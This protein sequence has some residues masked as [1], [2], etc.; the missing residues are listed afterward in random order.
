MWK[1][2]CLL[3][4]LG[5]SAAAQ[6]NPNQFSG[7]RWRLVGPFRSGRVS[8]VAGV[9]GDASTYYLGN[10]EGGVFKT[11][12]GGTVWTPIFAAEPVSSIGALAVAPSNPNVVYV[13]SGDVVN[14]GS[15]VN[16]GDGVYKSTDA[17]KTWQHLGLDDTHHISTVLISPHD[18]N[19]VLVAALGHTFSANPER[20]IY[21][22]SD[23]GTNWTKVLYRG[24]KSG[25]IDLVADPQNFNEMFAA[26]EAHAPGAPASAAAI[27]KSADAGLHWTELAG[28]GMPELRGRIGLAVA[29]HTRGQRVF[30]ITS[31]GLYRSDDAGASWHRAT[32][33]RRIVGAGYFSRVYVSPADPDMVYVMQ[34]C[35]YR[36][37]DGGHTFTAWKGA[38]GGDDYHE[39]WIDP[40]NAQR[41][42]LGVDQGETI[43]LNGGQQWS[44]GWT[45]LANGQFYH[46]S[47]DHRFP[48][49]IYGTQQDS[50]SAAVRSRGDFGEITF[51]DWRPSVGAY[52]FGYIQPDLSDANYVFAT[53]GGAALNRYDWKTRQI[54]DISPPAELGGIRLRYATSPEAECGQQA[55]C[56]GAQAV[57]RTSDRGLHWQAMSP[58][59]TGGG[60]AAITALAPTPAVN[61]TMWVGTSDGRVVFCIFG[62][63]RPS[64]FRSVTPS[65]VPAG[66]SISMIEAGPYR[67]STA[68]VVFDRHTHNDFAPYIFRTRDAGNHWTRITAGIPDGDFVRVVRADAQAHNLLFAGTEHGAFVSFNDGDHWQPLQ[69][70]LP[71]VSVRDLV[72][73]GDDLVAGTYGRAIWILDDLSPLRALAAHPEQTGTR[74][75]APQGA[76]RV[77]PDVNYDT[78][79]PPEM[80]TGTNPPAGAI[81]DYYLAAPAHTVTLS[82]Y[83]FRHHLIRRLTST[84]PA[85]E[86]PPQLAIPNY[87][88]A[89]PQPLP[90]STGMHRVVWDL[91]YA[92]PP[93]FA[94]SQPIAALLHDTP[95]DPRGP[96]VTPGGYVVVLD[97]DGRPYGRSTAVTMDPRVT[98]LTAGLERQRDLG[99][100]LV[101]AMRASYTAAGQV[102]LAIP[103]ALSPKQQELLGALRG[104]GRRRFRR[105]A[106]PPSGPAS[107]RQLNTQLG[108]LITLIELSD[109]APTPSMADN[110]QRLCQRLRQS[111]QTWSGLAGDKSAVPRA[112][113]AQP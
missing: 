105:R 3:F 95:T 57:L 13:G 14:V 41:M 104:S 59:L 97:V 55:F 1:R 102:A 19:L 75:F 73:Y 25:A 43:S 86:P 99:L 67:A 47:V 109:D 58:D 6:V 16:E 4:A 10:P 26:F 61:N 23:G 28:H 89:R 11:T 37:S 69:L 17:G 87:W 29:G 84:P 18:P 49:W 36:S 78:P 72:D 90:T 76:V 34:T 81:L 77:Q 56:L 9:P 35:A 39:M 85:P 21:R 111:L 48:F 12:S 107:F 40:T 27:Y 52:E 96:L 88:L 62:H 94:H 31:A 93:S 30:A 108:N 20:G 103:A 82:V 91:R 83:D 112:D 46:I 63:N 74:L 113:C 54:L 101:A 92:P 33:D 100:A 2:A 42:I 8:A 22:S 98:T 71:A 24:P 51:M 32:S 53:G 110:Y 65:Q 50:G 106:A 38:P 45:N 64:A 60:V 79:F 7:M 80:A 68:Y 5:L 15:S 44:L 66:T 70:N